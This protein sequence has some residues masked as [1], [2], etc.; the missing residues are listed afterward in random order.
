MLMSEVHLLPH[1]TGGQCCDEGMGAGH[2]E[3][4]RAGPEQKGCD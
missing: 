1:G 4:C 3:D 2:T